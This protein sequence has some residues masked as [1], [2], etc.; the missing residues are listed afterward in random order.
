MGVEKR[1]LKPG[2]EKK[3][4]DAKKVLLQYQE[5]NKLFCK[6]DACGFIIPK[7]AAQCPRCGV[8]FEPS[9]EEVKLAAETQVGR[10]KPPVSP[11]TPEQ[12]EEVKKKELTLEKKAH[13]VPVGDEDMET[14]RFPKGLEWLDDYFKPEGY[15]EKLRN[16]IKWGH[17]AKKTMKGVWNLTDNLEQQKKLLFVAIKGFNYVLEGAKPFVDSYNQKDFYEFFNGDDAKIWLN[18]GLGEVV[19]LAKE[20]KVE[21]TPEEM[22]N[23]EDKIGKYVEKRAE[24]VECALCHE[25]IPKDKLTDH[26]EECAKKQLEKMEAEER[27]KLKKEKEESAAKGV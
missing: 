3:V 22:K 8:I 18:L 7:V 6:C 19:R 27:E 4:E 17:D 16:K 9:Q 20:D 5:I 24:S 11:L 2:E 1:K 14:S 25:Q 21:L 12:L 15:L 13:K 10:G 23:F 26:S